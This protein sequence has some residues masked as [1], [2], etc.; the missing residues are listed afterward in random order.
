MVV[1]AILL[2]IAAGTVDGGLLAGLA[3]PKL[4]LSLVAMHDKLGQDWKV[5]DLSAI[6]G[7][8]RAQYV[9]VFRKTV[10]QPQEHI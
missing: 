10:G 7:L 4:Y 5:P 3:H 6:A 9:Q 1:Q 2:A 8:P